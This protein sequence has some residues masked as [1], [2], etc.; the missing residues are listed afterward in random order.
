M[1]LIGC[2]I[3]FFYSEEIFRILAPEKWDELQLTALLVVGVF[4]SLPLGCLFASAP[5]AVLIIGRFKQ[6]MVQVMCWL[7]AACIA[8][9]SIS[10]MHP[11]WSNFELGDG[12]LASGF[13]FSPSPLR[14]LPL[15]GAACVLLVAMIVRGAVILNRY[16]S[17]ACA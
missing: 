2:A 14:E 13:I 1:F 15:S 5:L 7:V 3:G 11:G 16:A 6:W 12:L 8:C 9:F 17:S 10:R 4:A